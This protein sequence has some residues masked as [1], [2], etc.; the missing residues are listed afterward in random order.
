MHRPALAMMMFGAWVTPAS[1]GSAGATSNAVIMRPMSIAK[2]ADLDFGTLVSSAT[3][4]TATLDPASGALAVTGGV[5]SIGTSAK[6]ARFAASGL[7]NAV[8]LVLLPTTITLTRS[9][10]TQAMTISAVTSNG[11]AVQ[12]FPAN[13]LLDIRVGGTLNIGAAQVEENYT[14]TF[15]VTVFYF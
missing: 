10:G 14:G 8:A 5:T 4:G 9:G 3:A 1:A 7:F 12:L 2:N 13:K 6:P 11:P 15:A